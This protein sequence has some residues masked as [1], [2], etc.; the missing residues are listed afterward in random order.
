[1]SDI[2]ARDSIETFNEA[3][4]PDM[5]SSYSETVPRM[6]TCQGCARR[7]FAMSKLPQ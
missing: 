3:A 7:I 1:M 4:F 6:I 5:T 2:L